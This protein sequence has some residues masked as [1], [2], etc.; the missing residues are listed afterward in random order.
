VGFAPVKL[1]LLSTAPINDAILDAASRSEL[2]TVVAVA[3]RDPARAGAYARERG[4][5]RVHGSYEAL[6]A[7]PDVEAVYVSVPNA[8]HA[9]W[10]IRALEAGKHVLV[11][12]P[13]TRHP[14]EVERAHDV[15]DRHGLRLTEGLT[16]R[17]H[18]Q[19][20][21]LP[22]LVESGAIGELRTLTATFRFALAPGDNTRLRPELD[23]GALMDVGCYCVSNLRLL[24]GEPELVHAQRVAGPTGVDLRAVATLRFP[25]D[26]LAR[27]EVAMDLPYH[28]TL[29]AVGDAGS[30]SLDKDFELELRRGDA[31]ERIPPPPADPFRRELE[32]LCAA[33][34]GEEELLLGRDDALGQARALDALLR[35]AADRA[36]VAL[37]PL[38]PR[39]R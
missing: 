38:P 8:L 15:A 30:L 5:A 25:G 18:P 23:G 22:E 10:S 32:N 16:P 6:L 11:E 9:E 2:A 12:K 26:V 3:S 14:H 28:R 29:E 31:V 13:F 17:H 20:A 21:R 19:T 4:I 37:D 39:A 1:G 34:R 36:P 33:I 24:A 7:D 35:S 27:I